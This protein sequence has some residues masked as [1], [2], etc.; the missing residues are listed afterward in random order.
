ME[1]QEVNAPG[2]LRHLLSNKWVKFSI[3][4]LIFTLWVVWIGNYWLLIGLPIVYDVYVSKKVHW[5]F[6]KK[7]GA[8]KQT[9]AVEWIDAIIFAVVAASLIRIF[10]IEAFTIPTPS[11]EKSLLVGDYLFVSKV[12]YG[13]KMP[14]TPIAFPFAHHTLPWSKKAKAYV[15]WVKWPYKRL[16]GWGKIKR[17]D[18]VVFNFPEGDTVVL[19]Y[20]DQS[21]YDQLRQYGRDYLWQNYEVTYR[22]VDKRE[23]YIKR[24]VGIPGDSIRIVHGQ[25]YVNGQPQQKIGEVQYK[26]RIVTR[27]MPLNMNKLKRMGISHSDIANVSTYEYIIPLTS[28]NVEKIKKF[29][30]VVSIVKEE[31]PK[32]HW[33]EYIFPHDS[34][35][36][37]NE[38]NFGPLW[39]PRKGVTVPI[40]RANIAL[41]R[42]IIEV[43]E[44]D[45]SRQL[46][47]TN[48]QVFLNGKPLKDYT[49]AMD[50]FWLMGDS[51]HNSAD[52]RYWGFVPEDHVVGKASFVWL[53]LDKEQNLFK[54]IR[55]NRLFM[56]I[57]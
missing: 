8:K 10:F 21:Y 41:Y 51:R 26:Y 5:A 1:N 36:M 20:P 29:S 38:D 48:D 49:F 2:K 25:L 14:N 22:P 37:W 27:D 19:E 46:E 9:K 35:L 4:A 24:C 50:Y 23:N 11:M 32:G 7:K 17:N 42:R 33:S 16:A 54:K 57:H 55:W 45:G 43:Y 39:I 3:A 40:S 34:L 56:G 6:W 52:S 15:E 44:N 18:V 47:I 53:S 28:T 30:N 31:V 12:A 13:P